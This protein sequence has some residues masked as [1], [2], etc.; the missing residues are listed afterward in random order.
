MPRT[1]KKR[2]KW[3]KSKLIYVLQ[4]GCVFPGVLEEWG[5]MEAEDS[6]LAPRENDNVLCK[7]EEEIFRS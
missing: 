6:L 5:N 2:H 7:S 4:E 3:S 1:E